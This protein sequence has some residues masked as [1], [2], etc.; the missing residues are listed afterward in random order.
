MH[1]VARSCAGP[2][3]KELFDLLERNKSPIEALLRTVKG[4]TSYTMMRTGDGGMTFTVC[5]DKASTDESVAVARDWIAKNGANIGA[6][7]PQVTDGTVI[8]H[9]K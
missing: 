1:A 7:P 3:P 9:L 6:Q 2:R 4:F 8:M 5:Q